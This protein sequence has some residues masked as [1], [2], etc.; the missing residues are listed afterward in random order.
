MRVL[1]T[2][3]SRLPVSSCSAQALQGYAFPYRVTRNVWKETTKCQELA[4]TLALGFR[5][6]TNS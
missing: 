1:R 6:P 5:R 4:D 3:G 2:R